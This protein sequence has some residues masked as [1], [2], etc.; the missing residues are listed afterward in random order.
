MSTILS[1][2]KL[3][4]GRLLKSPDQSTAS[5]VQLIGDD[6]RAMGIPLVRGGT[7]TSLTNEVLRGE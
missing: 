3:I 2:L 1:D 7:L 5:P 6:V 4:F